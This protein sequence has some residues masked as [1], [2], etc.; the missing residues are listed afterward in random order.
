MPPSIKLPRGLSPA[1]LAAEPAPSIVAPPPAS[2]VVT[3]DTEILTKDYADPLLLASVT[4][5]LATAKS[6]R[7]LDVFVSVSPPSVTSA[8]IHVKVYAINRGVRALVGS[9]C[10]PFLNFSVTGAAINAP[11]WVCAVRGVVAERFEVE[12][13]YMQGAPFAPVARV[14]FTAAAS[15]TESVPPAWVGTAPMGRLLSN[16]GFDIGVVAPGGYTFRGL[17]LVRLQAVLSTAS[18]RYL[19]VHD[20]GDATVHPNG[21]VPLMAWPIGAALGQGLNVDSI[22]YRARGA[23]QIIPSSTPLTTT[24][25][26][27]CYVTAT[28]R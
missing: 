28:V 15:N 13:L 17:E 9:G 22:N 12:A 20:V 6:W 16:V 11:L 23:L 19:H 3:A 26:A 27:D 21:Q 14:Q 25:A 4:Q 1:A 5:V 24:N 2:S 8:A 10:V 18:P 7:S